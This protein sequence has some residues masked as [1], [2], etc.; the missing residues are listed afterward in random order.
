MSLDELENKI[1]FTHINNLRKT[2]KQY[3]FYQTCML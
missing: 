1:V 3:T 2:Q